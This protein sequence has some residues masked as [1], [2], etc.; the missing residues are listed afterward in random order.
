[1]CFQPPKTPDFLPSLLFPPLS[2]TLLTHVFDCTFS[3][4]AAVGQ[5]LQ[6]IPVRP[7]YIVIGLVTALTLL[8]L[9]GVGA[10][11]LW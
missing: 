1:M 4:I 3:N 2:H 9:F 8:V 7:A 6:N 5:L 10:N 11:A